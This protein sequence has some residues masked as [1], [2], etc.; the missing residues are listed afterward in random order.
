[1]IRKRRGGR[2]SVLGGGTGVRGLNYAMIQKKKIS[3]GH[4]RDMG[5]VQSAV[6]RGKTLIHLKR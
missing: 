5:K 2:K 1:M 4:S 3:R 6:S